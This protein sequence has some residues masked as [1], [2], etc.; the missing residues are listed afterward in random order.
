MTWTTT[1]VKDATIPEAVMTATAMMVLYWKV[2]DTH[3][4]VS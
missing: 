1:A 2:M 3:V 4:Q